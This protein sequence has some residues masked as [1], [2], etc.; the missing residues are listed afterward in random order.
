MKAILAPVV[1]VAELAPAVAWAEVEVA[2]A[3]L[4]ADGDFLEDV[5]EEERGAA[6]VDGGIGVFF[7]DAECVSED[8]G[9]AVASGRVA[10]DFVDPGVE[11]D[12]PGVVLGVVAGVG[13][14][15]DHAVS[16]N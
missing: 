2:V 4:D 15:E 14:E 9:E 1:R 6:A 10:D 12:G 8:A 11:V 7:G 3:E 13:G 16:A 5:D